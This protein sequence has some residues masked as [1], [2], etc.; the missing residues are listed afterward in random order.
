MSEYTHIKKLLQNI[1]YRENHWPTWDYMDILID[2]IE[3]QRE[4]INE[5]LANIELAHPEEYKQYRELP[6]VDEAYKLTEGNNE[7]LRKDLGTF[8][9]DTTPEEL[10]RLREEG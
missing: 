7:I 9:I 5:L 10:Q 3:K 1:K 4:A 6:A 2:I 8:D